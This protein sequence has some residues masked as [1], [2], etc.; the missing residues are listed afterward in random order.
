MLFLNTS[1]TSVS[2]ERNFSV[3]QIYGPRKKGNDQIFS[4]FKANIV[5]ME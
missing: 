3:L 2:L 4:F 5:S 1:D